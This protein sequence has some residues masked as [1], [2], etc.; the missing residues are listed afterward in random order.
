MEFYYKEEIETLSQTCPPSEYNTVEIN[1]YRWV[2][3]DISNKNNF[4]AQADKSP[5][6]LNNKSDIKKCESYALSFHDT[7]E[8]SRN[9]FHYFT[10]VVKQIHK[11]LGT[12]IAI[13][14]LEKIDGV[15]SLISDNGHFN[16]HHQKNHNFQKKFKI[17]SQ[18]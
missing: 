1:C 12:H 15:G 13:G 17:I 7:E 2:F 4:L 5:K 3:G 18:L 8:N 10:G 11:R 6:I 14:K 16:F 9:H